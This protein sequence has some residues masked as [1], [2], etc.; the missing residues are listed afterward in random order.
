MPKAST[1]SG[2]RLQKLS[3]KRQP[4]PWAGSSTVESGRRRA[5]HFGMAHG[6]FI[7]LVKDTGVKYV[8]QANF[9]QEKL[10]NGYYLAGGRS[11][12]KGAAG[13]LPRSRYRGA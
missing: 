1:P 9:I 7:R 10:S 4:S 12:G 6:P 2:I 11:P 13:T 5:L 8:F 3:S